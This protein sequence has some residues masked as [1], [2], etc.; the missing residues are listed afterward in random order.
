MELKVKK[1][2]GLSPFWLFFWSKLE[3]NFSLFCFFAVNIFLLQNMFAEMLQTF[4]R[5]AFFKRNGKLL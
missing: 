2:F 1:T 4:L 3:P 5:T